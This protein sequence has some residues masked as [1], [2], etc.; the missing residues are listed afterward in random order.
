MNPKMM[1]MLGKKKERKMDD[2]E[3]EA[4][5]GVV[6]EMRDMASS[7]MGEKLKGL[8]K[9]TVASDSEKGLGFGLEK[10]KEMLQNKSEEGEEYAEE[11]ELENES[12][13][14]SHEMAECSE[15]ELDAKIK[16]LMALKE[17][18]KA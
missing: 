2:L 3:K 12:E 14:D 10:A 1:A 18:F 15:E 5:M 17:K 9:V 6:K 4:K 7:A 11:D 8:K 16:E 13:N